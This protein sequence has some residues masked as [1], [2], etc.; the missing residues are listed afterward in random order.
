MFR[1]KHQLVFC[2]LAGSMLGH[3]SYGL[4]ANVIAPSKV[5]Q[6]MKWCSTVSQQQNAMS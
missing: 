3:K 2:K 6:A 4:L 1:S 5:C